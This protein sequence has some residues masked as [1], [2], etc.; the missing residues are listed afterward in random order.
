M[1]EIR[2]NEM[3][4]IWNNM[5]DNQSSNSTL[6]PSNYILAASNLISTAYNKLLNTAI[7]PKNTTSNI[8]DIFDNSNNSLSNILL[9]STLKDLETTAL[10][11][12]TN[13]RVN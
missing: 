3:N 10:R 6:A 8:L 4:A 9:F 2:E 7:I 13:S 12:S 11:K 5:A 1:A